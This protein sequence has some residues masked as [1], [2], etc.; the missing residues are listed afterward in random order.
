[1]ITITNIETWGW[2]HAIRGMRNPLNS[3]DRSDSSFYRDLECDKKL[4]PSCEVCKEFSEKRCETF[5]IGDKDLDLMKRLFKAGTEH[6]KYLRQI[7]VSM[8]IEAPLYWYKEMETYKVGTVSN[9][10]STMHTLFK[11]EL[12]IDDFSVDHLADYNQEPFEKYIE[13]LN[14]EIQ[15][16]H[17]TK[18]KMHWWQVIQMLPSSF[19][20]KRTITM[21]YEN[22]FTILKQREGHKLDEW[23]AFCETL[24]TLPYVKEISGRDEE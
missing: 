6:R 13:M 5:S 23:K 17:D 24:K 21:N 12:S 10:T 20:Q 19:N 18:D 7:F 8:D 11:E 22:V 2:R 4:V 15:E 16:Y 1:M 9:S 3:W 14:D